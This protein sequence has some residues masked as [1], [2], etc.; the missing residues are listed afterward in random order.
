VAAVLHRQGIQISAQGDNRAANT[1]DIA[2]QAGSDPKGFWSEPGL[3]EATPHGSGRE[4]LLP[5][6]FGTTVQ[7]ASELDEFGLVDAEKMINR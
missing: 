2:R 1:T 7:I 6:E 5:A 3:A 4:V